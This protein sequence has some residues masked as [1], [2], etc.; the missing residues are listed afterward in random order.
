[1]AG[2]EG[3]LSRLPTTRTGVRQFLAAAGLSPL[4]RFG[5]NFLVRPDLLD[6][7]A[8]LAR[9]DPADR[10]LEVGPGLG[11]LTG[12][13]LETGA[14]V[15]AAEVDRG[16]AARLQEAF[17]GLEDFQLVVGDVMLSKSALAPEVLAALETCRR[18][19][20]GPWLVASNL[21]F[22]I[23]SPFIGAL[24]NLPSGT[25]DRG[26]VMVQ[27]EVAA[28]LTARPGSP[29]WSPL[30]FAAR[31]YLEVERAFLVP[32]SAFEPVPE[33][34]GAVV[35]LRRRGDRAL[36]PA[37]LLPFARRLFQGRR[38]TL[39]AMLPAALAAAG[40]P[41]QDPAVRESWLSRAGLAPTDR[42]D[43]VEPDRIE[44]LLLA[45]RGDG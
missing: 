8:A 29:D 14:R 24:V 19:G 32:A 17:G 16:L 30:A 42:I 40:L 3:P 31:L 21:P 7:I 27:R 22:Q 15:V 26:V 4:K 9:P 18:P 39:R 45:A 34:D 12:R 33:V 35:T 28:V 41:E 36:S 11:A 37:E 2:A 25:W 10:V 23:S 13:L 6:R 38:K 5:Q 43:A 44:G 20:D 1:M